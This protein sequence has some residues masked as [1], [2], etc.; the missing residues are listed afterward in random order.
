MSLVYPLFFLALAL[1]LCVNFP[2]TV[3]SCAEPSDQLFFDSLMKLNICKT[4]CG[5]CSTTFVLF[6]AMHKQYCE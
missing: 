4:T 1:L 2:A 5:H 3:Y 6:D